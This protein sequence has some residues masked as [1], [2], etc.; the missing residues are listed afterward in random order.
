MSNYNAAATPLETGA[1][2]KKETYDK[3][4]SVT[5]YKQIIGSLRYLCNARPNICQSVELLNR[6]MEKPQECHFTAVKRV[7]R[8]I[9][10]MIDHDVLMPRWKKTN[11][12]AEVYGYTDSDFSGDQDEKKSTANYIFMI[13]S[14]SISWS[15]RKQRI[16]ALP[17]CE[18][19]YMD[20]SYA[21]CQ[22]AW[23][24]MLLEDLKI[25]EPRKMKL[26]INNKSVIDLTNH[27]ACHGQCKHI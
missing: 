24:E 12:Y 18:V 22:V 20:V 23:I 11:T 5:L 2:L 13:E 9:K 3:F 26:F 8:Y 10:G 7:M 16:M 1:K 6:I 27:L 14:A 15:S 21:T 4:L 25:M 19:E 17:S